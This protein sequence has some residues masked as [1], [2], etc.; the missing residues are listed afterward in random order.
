MLS[1]PKWQYVWNMTDRL[2]R[3]RIVLHQF[4]SLKGTM[5]KRDYVYVISYLYVYP[6]LDAHFLNSKLPLVS[7]VVTLS[8]MGIISFFE[9]ALV[10]KSST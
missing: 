8:R 9:A 4:R 5:E 3:I 6:M 10:K 7:M 1:L 2:H